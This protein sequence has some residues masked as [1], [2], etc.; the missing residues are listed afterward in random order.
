MEFEINKREI[1]KLFK[2]YCFGTDKS[3]SG[4]IYRPRLRAFKQMVN[5]AMP[6]AGVGFTVFADVSEK[7]GWILVNP[8]LIRSTDTTWLQRMKMFSALSRYSPGLWPMSLVVEHWKEFR[9]I[10]F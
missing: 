3:F 7:W 2:E 6:G 10:A 1:G 4:S 9:K 8:Y 5:W